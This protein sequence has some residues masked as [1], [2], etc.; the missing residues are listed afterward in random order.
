MKTMMSVA[1]VGMAALGFTGSADAY[2]LS[3]V[4][5]KFT[6]SG[7]ASATLNGV[8]L[9]GTG[10]FNGDVNKKGKGKITKVKFCGKA[11][12][13]DVGAAGLPWVM[14]ATGATT[15]TIANATFT[16]PVGDCGPANLAV[17]IS[18]GVMS[19]NGPFD[20]CTNVNLSFTTKPAI[21][22]VR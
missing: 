8:T 15:A 4:S 19:Y 7:P 20:Q 1:A 17:T 2:K 12:C 11:G 13:G 6:A 5:T 14:K 3:P 16:S 21:S 10:T 9:T 18:G 22:I